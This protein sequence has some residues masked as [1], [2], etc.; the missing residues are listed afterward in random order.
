MC[1][2]EA[3]HT[4]CGLLNF[5]KVIKVYIKSDKFDQGNT[6]YESY[7]PHLCEDKILSK[8]VLIFEIQTLYAGLIGEKIYYKEICG[9]DTFPMNLRIGSSGDINTAS[10]L[11]E[12]YNLALA[13]NPR[14]LLKKQIQNDTKNILLEYWE[15]VRLISHLLYKYKELN[16]SELKRFL[17]KKSTNKEL[18]RKKFRDISIIYN[19]KKNIEEGQIKE[20]LLKNSV[21]II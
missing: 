11:I 12:K 15:D 13:G 1:W 21:V 8:I 5:I 14:F 3:S 16:H 2:H 19:D 18:W 4:I 10:S 17:T 20:I 9:S 7:E 6:V